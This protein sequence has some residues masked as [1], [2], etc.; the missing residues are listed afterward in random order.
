MGMSLAD[1]QQFVGLQRESP[2]WVLERVVDGLLGDGTAF[3]GVAGVAWLQETCVAD[4]YAAVIV[5]RMDAVEDDFDFVGM[6]QY[7]CGLGP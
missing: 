7:G 4:G 5:G 1:A 3:V 6:F 2:L